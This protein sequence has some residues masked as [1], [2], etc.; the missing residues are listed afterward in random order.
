MR[1]EPFKPGF[2][3]CSFVTCQ[4]PE[5]LC[6]LA[7]SN[8]PTV[9]ISISKSGVCMHV[10]KGPAGWHGPRGG[11]KASWAFNMHP[12]SPVGAHI[13]LNSISSSLSAVH[14]GQL[15]T[16]LSP[17][18]AN[19]PWKDIK[20]GWRVELERKEEQKGKKRT[21]P[22]FPLISLFAYSDPNNFH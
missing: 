8:Q 9:S 17:P 7:S 12:S 4:P 19:V 13:T 10:A 3:A 18:R 14:L 15:K 6:S 20:R 2:E 16:H 21:K 1:T 22:C 11:C 5:S